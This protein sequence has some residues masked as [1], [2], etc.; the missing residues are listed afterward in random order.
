VWLALVRPGNL[1]DRPAVD[2]EL[3]AAAASVEAIDWGGAIRRFVVLGLIVGSLTVSWQFLRAWLP[4]FLED[5]QGYSKLD[6]RLAVSGYYIAAEVGCLLVGFIV[7]LFVRWGREVHRARVM[8][9]VGY[10]A[11]TALAAAVPFLGSGWMMIAGLMIA[12]AGILGLHPL[13]YALSQELPHRRMGVLSGALAAGG[14][15]VSSINQILIGARIQ[16][17]KSY[18]VGLVIAGLAPLVGLVALLVLWKPA[19]GQASA[20][21]V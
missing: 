14:W 5:F 12:G 10:T 11:L 18:D 2:E 1:D 17:T 19:N 8:A 13:Y 16:A 20:G 6:S 4:L 15:V 21:R 7:M 3:A 9:F